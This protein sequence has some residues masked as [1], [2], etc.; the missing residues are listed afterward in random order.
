MHDHELQFAI[1]D[2]RSDPKLH[3]SNDA[4]TP[5][6]IILDKIYIAIL[7]AALIFLIIVH[8]AFH[9]DQLSIEKK[10]LPLM[11]RFIMGMI[12][13]ILVL[14]LLKVSKVYY[15]AKLR[16]HASRHHLMDLFKLL[17]RIILICIVLSVFYVNWY[18]AVVS[19]GLI[20]VIL[21]FA[22][23]TPVLSLIGWVYILV[24]KPYKIGDRIKVGEDAG[25]VIDIDFLDTTMWEVKGDRLSSDQ[26]SGKIIRFP[27]SNI[28]SAS[29]FNYS[30]ALFPFIYDEVI[31]Y[32]PT[33][34]NIG[35]I[36]KILLEVAEEQLG[37]DYKEQLS[38]FKK[39]L[40]E[41]K[42]PME[43]ISEDPQVYF[44]PNDP[45][46]LMAILVY[47]VMPKLSGEKSKSITQDVLRRLQENGM[48]DQ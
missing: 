44:K 13:V 39:L 35:T 9:L 46:S 26:H 25:D 5:N 21:G 28:L 40:H 19:L 41:N 34:S 29:V 20:S 6:K 42:I 17:T 47:P 1:D 31:F 23:Q 3:S 27:N 32:L 14:L 30:W 45:A 38:F 43:D 10:Y 7:L 16:S 18:T 2:V 48:N 37:Q 22:L 33:N 24:R 11:P 8:Y 12:S 36:S 4:F 15:L